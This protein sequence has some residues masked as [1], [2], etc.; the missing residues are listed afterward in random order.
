MEVERN[1]PLQPMLAPDPDRPILLVYPRAEPDWPDPGKLLGLPLAVLT[2]ARGLVAAGFRVRILDEN[3]I[4]NTR[5]ALAAEERPL[6]VG[7]SVLG[8][9]TIQSGLRIAELSAELW[10]GVPRVWGGWN[11]TLL[12]HL[13]EAEDAAGHVDVVVRGRGEATAVALAERLREQ[14]RAGR[15]DLT[16]EGI[17]GLSWRDAD[18]TLQR[19]PDAELDDPSEAEALPYD[20]IEDVA[21]YITRNGALNFISSYGCPHR[22]SFCGIPAY[23]R[24]FRATNVPRVVAELGRLRARGV[25][26]IVF[27]D[28]NFFT[29][30]ARVID[31]AAGLLEAGVD[32]SWHCNGRIDQLLR[33]DV[34]DLRLLVRSGCRGVNV[35]WETG[36]QE[37][38]DAVHKDVEVDD[39]FELARRFAAADLHLS[40]NLMVGLPGETPE[41]LVRTLESLG[42]IHALQPDL[43]VCWYLFMP[44]PGT[45][46]WDQLVREGVLTEP[47]SLFEHARL[48]PLYLEHPW[49]YVSPPRDV[50]REWR[51]QHKA[52]VWTFWIAFAANPP[53]RL[54]RPAF[55]LLRRW[56]RWRFATRRFGWLVDWRIA[57]AWNALRDRSRWTRRRLLR[58]ALL[59]RLGDRLR[60]S[61]PDE[62]QYVLVAGTHRST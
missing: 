47:S 48:Q 40:L 28:D 13:Y 26:T 38:A 60:R 27:L 59:H 44:A 9:Y 30:K 46:L 12:P 25:N 18:G 10:P 55:A 54:L 8:G 49:Y 24:T 16:L 42:R 15:V 11:P 43:E 17:P 36:D 50:F 41:A 7:I 14:A 62:E 52:I 2:V 31:L 58:S 3:V 1:A 56:C 20:L 4:G 22:C 37:L 5:A 57:F 34:D 21:P 19:T 53:A 45:E 29:T 35:G 51:T 6:F 32:L 23:T 61:K 39:V 33:L